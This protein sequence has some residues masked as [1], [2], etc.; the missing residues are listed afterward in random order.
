MFIIVYTT[1]P[2]NEAKKLAKKIIQEK[3]AGCI[4]IIDSVNSI[5]IWQNEIK[6]EEESLLII[7]T[8]QS[9]FKT[10]EDFIINNHPYDVP[11]IIATPLVNANLEYLNWLDESVKD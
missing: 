7:K 8:K 2:K 5:Y 6:D 9:V 11:E 4:N 3:L 1:I 10:L